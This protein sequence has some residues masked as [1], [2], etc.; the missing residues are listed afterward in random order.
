[1]AYRSPLIEDAARSGAMIAFATCAG[2]LLIGSVLD[3]AWRHANLDGLT[4]LPSRRPFDQRLEHLVGSYALAV[5][6][7]DHFKQ[8]ND[9]FGHDT[10]DQVLRRVAACLRQT[11]MGTPYR[12]GGEEFVL[13]CPDDDVLIADLNALRET[14]ENT[15]FVVRSVDRPSHKPHPPAP[16]IPGKEVT[17]RITVSIGVARSAN[18]R[19]KPYEVLEAA[20]HAL[21]EAKGSGRNR[22]VE[23]T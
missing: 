19:G 18:G 15:R 11:R 20:D 3:S 8:I 12:Y 21:Y 13:I 14:V 5:L 23:A 17:V 10:G 1:L 16:H 6:D 22:V 2:I 7:I 4:G 9:R